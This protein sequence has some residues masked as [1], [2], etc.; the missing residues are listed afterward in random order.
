M[1]VAGSLLLLL[2]LVAPA[3]AQTPPPTPPGGG[4]TQPPPT[5]PPTGD[6]ELG[7]NPGGDDGDDVDALRQ[8]YL[9]LRDELFQSRARAAAVASAL[10]SSK[11]TIKLA[12]TAGRFYAVDRASVRLDG[13]SVYD[14]TEGKITEDDATRFEGWIAPGRH[15]VAIR[16]EATGKDDGR[17]T[18]A[19]EAS[20]VVEA[21]AGKDLVITARAK[22][23]GDIPYAWSRGE[24]GS[25]QLSI[26]A[27]VKTVARPGETGKKKTASAATKTST[28]VAKKQAKKHKKGSRR[29]AGAR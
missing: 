1:K 22:D 12:Y 5:T 29:V 15:V 20:F 6:D 11:V 21:V 8:E 7:A 28:K 23:S 3:S 25:Y 18:S 26:D 27:D 13:A 14:D 24:H 19:S 9:K 4:G 2:A 17:F 16:V 10:Y